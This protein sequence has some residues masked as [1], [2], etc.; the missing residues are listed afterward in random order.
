MTGS[1]PLAAQ[2]SGVPPVSR[3]VDAVTVVPGQAGVRF[4]LGSRALTVRGPADVLSRAV[5]ALRAGLDEA[6][7]RAT[8]ATS[9]LG[10]LVGELT[11]LGWMTSEPAAAATNPTVER[12]VGYLSVFGPDAAAMQR[13]IEG[14]RVAILGVGGVGTVLA[15]HLAGAGVGE[16]WLVDFDRVAPHNLNRQFLFAYDDI[17]VPKTE[18]AARALRRLAPALVVHTVDARVAG[19]ADLSA[20]PAELDLLVVAADTPPGIHDFAWQWARGRR[21]PLHMSAVGLETGYWGPLL[22]PARA[23]CWDCFSRDRRDALPADQ[24]DLEERGLGPTPYSF[25]PSNTAVA[26]LLAHDVLRYLASGDSPALNRRG[27]L[28]L[29]EGRIS[30]FAGQSCR[31]SPAAG[32]SVEAANPAPPRVDER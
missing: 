27:Q 32:G 15:Q 19:A 22:V 14:A 28:M 2:P 12:Q 9:A 17:G 29:S 23:H 13:R 1:E 6:T 21:I 11:G 26:A 25:G 10:R 31:C 24:V 5:A 18:A 30:Y 8:P 7:L 16:L 4:C 20:L 3:L